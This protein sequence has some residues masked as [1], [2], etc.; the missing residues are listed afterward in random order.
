MRVFAS[1]TIKNMMGRFGIPEDEP[2]QNK[3]VSRAL[4]SAQ[5][6]I[7]GFNFDARKH[8]LE[9][10][11]VLDRQRRAVLRQAPRGAGRHAGR[12]RCGA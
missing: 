9:F 7:E 12:S 3:L 8:V 5:T 1:D 6:K 11:N 2:I 4:E 10:D